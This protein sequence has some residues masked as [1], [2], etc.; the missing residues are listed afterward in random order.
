MNRRNCILDSL[1]L[2]VLVVSALTTQPQ[3]VLAQTASSPG[4]TAVGKGAAA[5]YTDLGYGQYPRVTEIEQQLLGKTYEKDPLTT[6]VTRLETKQFGKA[7]P[8]DDLADR[9]DRL[10][11]FITP[12][13]QMATDDNRD[14]DDPS[15]GSPN[16]AR[17]T[18]SANSNSSA[19]AVGANGASGHVSTD[20]QY[21]ASDYG[22]YPRVTELEQQ[23]LGTTYVK[24]PLPVRIARLETKK[25][26]KT[27]PD[28]E[29]CDRIDRLD[30]LANP[31]QNSRMADSDQ[32]SSSSGG[33]GNS[34]SNKNSKA[35]SIG[36]S[37]L[38]MLGGAMG[39]GM[40]GLGGMGM[41]MM[42]NRMGGVG[43]G[44]MGNMMPGV[45]DDMR[46]DAAKKQQQGGGGSGGG[47]MKAQSAPVS[48]FSPD[49]AP[50]S[51]TENKLA[52]I[53]KFVLGKEHLETP[54]ADRVAHVEK[55]LVPYEHH[56]ASQD[57]A[58][59]IDHLWSILTAAN[60]PSTKSVAAAQS[61]PQD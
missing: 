54:M 26:G 31:K 49:A 43:N 4:P 1:S 40:G 61:S 57:L 27:T 50:V 42:G 30:K 13:T 37:L 18:P 16:I 2:T 28:A 41:G 22:N 59:R 52:A 7:S 11:K 34:N 17:A 21:S 12:K 14:S 24:D 53:E 58:L 10:D 38:G 5:S 19:S 55:K 47:L 60:K 29:L 20:S 51:G 56:Q 32:D 35:S 9:L 23:F 15:G 25:F 8:Q 44:G 6:R 48:P 33:N 3:A 39:G 45:Q 46:A 36:R